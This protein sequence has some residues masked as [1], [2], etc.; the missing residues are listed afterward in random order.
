[1][2]RRS[3]I[4]LHLEYLEIYKR[5]LLGKD[6][7]CEPNPFP[8]SIISEAGETHSENVVVPADAEEQASGPPFS[9]WTERGAPPPVRK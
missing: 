5:S 2:G 7:G 3:R 8:D 9:D 4:L 1:M 6:S